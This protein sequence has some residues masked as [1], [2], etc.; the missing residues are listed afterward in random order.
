MSVSEIHM[1]SSGSLLSPGTGHV[2]VLSAGMATTLRVPMALPEHNQGLEAPHTTTPCP[3]SPHRSIA[4]LPGPTE[5]EQLASNN[6]R[7]QGRQRAAGGIYELCKSRSRY[8]RAC[9]GT[10][11][12]VRTETPICLCQ[13]RLLQQSGPLHSALPSGAP[14]AFPP[15]NKR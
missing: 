11:S 1:T 5:S 2:A 4:C 13:D 9:Q 8:E 7:M 15:D 12:Q 6:K 3:S 14:A 10:T